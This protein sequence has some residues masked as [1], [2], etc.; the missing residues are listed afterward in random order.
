MHKDKQMERCSL[1]LNEQSFPVIEQ[2]TE[3]MPGGFFIYRAY[4]DEGLIYA[5]RAL[6]RMYGCDD[7]EEFQRYTGYTFPGLVHPEDIRQVEQSIQQQIVS[8]KTNFDYVEYRIVRRDG[9]IRWIED[10]GHFVRSDDYGDLFYVFVEDATERR[11]KAIDDARTAQLAQERLEA[12]RALK[13]EATAL[14]LVHEILKSGMWTMEFD[15]QGRMVGVNWSQDFRAMIGYTD[16]NDFPNELS[17]WSD[18]L[19]P[20]DRTRVLDHYYATIEDYTGKSVYDAEYRLLTRDRGYRWFRAAGKLSRR[21]DG[22]PITYVGTFVDITEQKKTDE[23]LQEQRKLLEAALDKAQRASQAKTVF[24][25]NMSHDIRTPMNAII[26]FT[27]LATTH[28]DDAAL[29][30]SYLD[31]IAASSNHLLSLIN[32]VLDM[33]RIESG[34]VSIEEAPC[35]LPEM[36]ENLE[37]I[38]CGD[39][40]AGKLEFS[41]DTS[42]LVHPCVVCDKLRLNQVLLNV[43]SNALKFTPA[44]GRVA[45]SASEHP[46]GSEDTAFYEFCI[47]DTGIGMAPKFIEH[48]FDPFERERTSTVSGIPGTGLGL[49]ITRN[50]VELMKGRISVESRQ[51]FGSAFTLTFL[52]RIGEAPGG[53]AAVESSGHGGGF[54]GRHLLLVEDNELNQEIAMTILEEAGYFVDVAS[55][56]AEAVNKVCQSLDD[57]Y[58]LILMDIQMPVMDGIEATR[59]IRALDDPQLSQVPIVAV[60]ANTFEEDRQRV[61]SAGMNGHLGKPIDVD[62]LLAKLQDMLG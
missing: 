16:E 41:L 39:L 48:I 47:Q 17:S 40:E 43:L 38:V 54:T 57:P 58:D 14:K 56:G 25:N 12:L 18:L 22:S 34:K 51:G 11:R 29:V 60:T 3:G 37:S 7:L 2:I 44:G 49:S 55:N 9:E 4:G 15:R 46:G 1:S 45:V 10:H 13:H 53:Q 32:D 5:N 8:D 20:D 28:L 61:L 62:K 26:G 27:N 31:K 36:L 23:Q 33:S 6:I 52:F 50:L 35:S 24:L 30:R 59:I 19:H 21:E 42:A